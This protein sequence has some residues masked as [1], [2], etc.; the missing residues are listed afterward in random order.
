MSEALREIKDKI[1]EIV[2]FDQDRDEKQLEKIKRDMIPLL[3]D[4]SEME[5]V[6]SLYAEQ[7][8]VS[9]RTVKVGDLVIRKRK[10][11]DKHK[12][13]IDQITEQLT[14]QNPTG[15]ASTQ[16]DE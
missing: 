3:E 10:V 13:G 2:S 1:I 12:V 4:S 6:I 14:V 11:T 8:V 5:K 16:N 15:V 7:I 9:K